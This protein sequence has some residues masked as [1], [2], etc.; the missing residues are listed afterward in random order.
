LNIQRVG[1]PTTPPDGDM[2][3]TSA[4]V[5][6]RVNGVTQTVQRAAGR[7]VGDQITGYTNPWVTTPANRA[8]GYDAATVT[9]PQLA[10]RVRALQDDMTTH[11]LIAV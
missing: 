10:A 3:I 5:F 1:T 8:T 9:L 6:A 2:W 4:N 11:G 7:V